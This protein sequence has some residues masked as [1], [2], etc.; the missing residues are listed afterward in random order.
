MPWALDLENW[1]PVFEHM[2]KQTSHGSNGGCEETS[3]GHVSHKSDYDRQIGGVTLLTWERCGSALWQLDR[4]VRFCLSEVIAALTSPTPA[5]SA[6]NCD[7][8]S[9]NFLLRKHGAIAAGK[10]TR[11][12]AIQGWTMELDLVWLYPCSELYV[13]KWTW[14]SLVE[15]LERHLQSIRRLEWNRSIHSLRNKTRSDILA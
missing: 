1:A 12:V 2:L 13:H 6:S 11:S 9:R 10:Q 4:L 8:W 14:A 7:L 5:R 3:R 15:T